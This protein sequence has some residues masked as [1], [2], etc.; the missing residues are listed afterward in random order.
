MMGVL[1]RGDSRAFEGFAAILKNTDQKRQKKRKNRREKGRPGEKVVTE[2]AEGSRNVPDKF[3]VRVGGSYMPQWDLWAGRCRCW[4][5]TRYESE[6]TFLPAFG[7]LASGS[8]HSAQPLSIVMS[9]H[10][11]GINLSPPPP[12]PSPIPSPR[13][14]SLNPTFSAHNYPWSCF[15]PFAAR[16]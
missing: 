5:E 9:H 15:L 8:P 13:P 4:Q 2:S 6:F 1:L 12:P 11:P 3:P 14:Q 7:R 10:L 16:G